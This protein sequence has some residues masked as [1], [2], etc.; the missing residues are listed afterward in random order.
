MPKQRLGIL[1]I[2]PYR[3]S[4]SRENRKKEKLSFTGHSSNMAPE[5]M[6]QEHPGYRRMR[7]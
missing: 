4:K 7:S 1:D 5:S 3:K 6:L 2:G